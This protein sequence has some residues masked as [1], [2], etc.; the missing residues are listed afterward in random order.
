[1]VDIVTLTQSVRGQLASAL[2]MGASIWQQNAVTAIEEHRSES[3][4]AF[5]IVPHSMKQQNI[6][7]VRMLRTQVPCVQ[8][9]TIR[10]RNL[11]V[12]KLRTKTGTRDFGCLID[13]PERTPPRM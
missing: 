10:S 1:M 8:T 5:A 11:N 4:D 7:S 12:L 13:M 9:H 3:G 6:A 2:P